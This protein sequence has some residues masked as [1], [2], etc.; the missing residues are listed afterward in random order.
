MHRFQSFVK[1]LRMTHQP[2][3]ETKLSNMVQLGGVFI[4]KAIDATNP[5][6]LLS[7]RIINSWANSYGKKYRI[8][9]LKKSSFPK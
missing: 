3:Q 8:E 2:F 5:L 4:P 7:F 6:L 1:L 9:I